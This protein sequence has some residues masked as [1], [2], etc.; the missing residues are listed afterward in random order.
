MSTHSSDPHFEDGGDT[1]GFGID[2]G[3][4]QQQ[5][6]SDFQ[7][8]ELQEILA[9]LE[10]DL[11]GSA[12]QN[13]HDWIDTVMSEDYNPDNF[14]HPST[15]PLQVLQGVGDS[16]LAR[17]WGSALDVVENTQPCLSTQAE[18]QAGNSRAGSAQEAEGPG[19]VPDNGLGHLLDELHNEQV[20]EVLDERENEVCILYSAPQHIIKGMKE[21]DFF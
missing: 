15:Q 20:D 12:N 1:V 7:Q 13:P 10:A 8:I 17:A 14:G 11:E 16:L 2:F 4:K 6:Q 21:N 5:T 9:G 19:E 3:D 18:G